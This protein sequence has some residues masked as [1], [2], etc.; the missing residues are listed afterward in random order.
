[1]ELVTVTV[2][3]REGYISFRYYALITI[4]VHKR[5]LCCVNVLVENI[6]DFPTRCF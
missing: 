5:A 4:C 1:M 2:R 6:R 3:F